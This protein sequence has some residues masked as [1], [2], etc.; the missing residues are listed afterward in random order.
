[1]TGSV[2]NNRL[3]YSFNQ[4]QIAYS[5]MMIDYDHAMLVNQKVDL[6]TGIISI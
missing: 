5:L 2:L 6:H 4:N 1:M 3:L